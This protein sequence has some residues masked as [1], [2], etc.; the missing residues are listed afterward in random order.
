[1][2]SETADKG[3]IIGIRHLQATLLF[4][5]I[6]VNY[7]GRNNVSVALVA[8]TN[9]ATTNPDFPE[10]DWTEVQK[11]YIL[12][13]FYWGYVITQFPA[14]FLV[15]RIGAKNVLMICTVM[16]TVL[17]AL[18]PYF[19]SWGGWEAFCVLRVSVGLSQG[20]MFPGLLAHIAK[21][22]PPKDRNRIGVITYA[23][24]A[25][26]LLLAMAI[27]GLIAEGPMGWPGI[28]YITAGLCGVW[29]IL[30]LVLAADN[31]P[32]SRWITRAECELIERSMQRTDGFH[33]QKIPIPWRAIWTSVP[34]YALLTVSASQ[35]WSGSTMNQQTPAYMRGVLDMDIKSNALYSALPYLA[36]WGMS[37]V[38][39]IIADLIMAKKWMTLNMMRKSLNTVSSWGPAAL[40]VWIGF[41]DKEQTTL[42]IA[43]MTIKSGIGAGDGLG[44]I[45][46]VI[47]MSPNHAGMVMAIVNGLSTILS[48]LTPLVVGVVVTDT[49]SRVQWQ[50]IFGLTAAILFVGNLVYI[51]WGST[52]L[53]R[54]DA[55]DF[56]KPRDVERS[57]SELKSSSK[58]AKD[59]PSKQLEY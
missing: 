17:S 55:V 39:L 4:L 7:I 18:T 11:S 27:S 43:L 1:M 16:T 47:D 6:C 33:A 10:Y 44:S 29:C 38:Y 46:T 53:Q 14:G 35:S 59:V 24:A 50:I 36:M 58:Q 23:G 3:P 22:S 42:A 37:F 8:M 32:S 20:L 25:C 40:L 2:S 51:I 12:S 49:S 56:L 30:W 9:A 13:S 52:D 57:P 15:R 41:L 45:I 54:W 31:A 28:Y 5:C 34:F 21:W 26:G 19:I 48:L